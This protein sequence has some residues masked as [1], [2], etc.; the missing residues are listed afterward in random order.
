MKFHVGGSG[1]KLKE[2]ASDWSTVQHLIRE[3]EA[4]KYSGATI[5]THLSPGYLNWRYAD[6]PLFPYQFL[7][8]QVSYLLIFRIKE[9]KMGRELRITD[10]FTLDSFGKN[11]KKEL[12]KELKNIQKQSGARFT[13]FS[14]LSYSN[15]QTPDLGILPV[16][17][18]GP[19]I[20]L[21]KVSEDSEPMNLPWGWSLGDLEVF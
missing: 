6:C 2:L 3:I 7:S 9:G 20:T 5:Q 16:L 13:S 4:Q 12:S 10:F 19:I 15:Q 18:I 17:S 14:G 11:Q 21:R 8:D 1:S